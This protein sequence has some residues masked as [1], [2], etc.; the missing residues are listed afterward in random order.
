MLLRINGSYIYQNI[1]A[2]GMGGSFKELKDF[3]AL[4]CHTLFHHR[5]KYSLKKVFKVLIK[6]K[7]PDGELLRINQLLL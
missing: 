5:K 1:E 6:V 4:I 7:L 2:L 3:L